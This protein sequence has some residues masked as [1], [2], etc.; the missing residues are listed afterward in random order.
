MKV[1]AVTLVQ[2]A[3]ALF[4]WAG[5]VACLEPEDELLA[6][7]NSE[8]T[9]GPGTFGG[10]LKGVPYS[11]HLHKAFW[12][13]HSTTLPLTIVTGLD[14]TRLDAL[15]AQ[16]KSWPGPLGAAVYVS[17]RHEEGS[18]PGLRDGNFAN[19]THKQTV[20][21]ATSDLQRLF[22]RAESGVSNRGCQLRIMLLYEFTADKELS[23][24]LPI[25]TIRNAA[26]LLADTPLVAMVDTD[27][28][29][30]GS[31][32]D[33]MT[34]TISWE[35]LLEACTKKLVLMKPRRDLTIL[36]PPPSHRWEPL[37][38]WEPLLEACTKK[39][40]VVV[41]PAFE[42]A[43]TVDIEKGVELTEKAIRGTKSDLEPYTKSNLL[44]PFAAQVYARGHNST[45]YPRWFSTPE[46]YSV[47]YTINYE[48]W[49]LID[50]MQSPSYDSRFR[51]YGW[52]KVQQLA[53]VH[54]SGS[55]VHC[56]ASVCCLWPCIYPP[57]APAPATTAYTCHFFWLSL[58]SSP[59]LLTSIPLAS[60]SQSTLVAHVNSSGFLFTV[61]PG[62]F[63]IHRPHA[64]S[65]AQNI[66][67]QANVKVKTGP[68][69][70][71]PAKLFHR[72]VA[73][74]RHLVMRDMKKGVFNP[75]VDS[76]SSRCRRRLSWWHSNA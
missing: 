41:L 31:L 57:T 29:I 10:F 43:K 16:C 50:R 76:P 39:R 65:S 42:T 63:L 52:N 72:K 11:L 69:S 28:V 14:L 38:D 58:H 33:D 21:E 2:C 19:A 66:Y 13:K 64:K 60:S 30:G 67:K 5:H 17:L 9:E 62:A 4:F 26:M 75:V 53:H 7:Y 47:P 37:L 24:L 27:L 51:G 46:R 54:S 1:T 59:W 34:K 44:I 61:H 3:A 20:D 12:S 48:P 71:P 36:Y 8:A 6:C 74:L 35:Q 55:Q 22:E 15:E 32:V 45:D 40:E 23:L 49:F 73:A 68:D 25:N 56:L 18:G 70:L